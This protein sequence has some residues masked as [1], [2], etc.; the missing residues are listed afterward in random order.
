MRVTG[1]N[2]LSNIVKII[3]QIVLILGIIIIIFLPFLVNL[4]NKVFH[5]NLT[6]F[7]YYGYITLL[8]CASIPAIIL[9]YKF[10]K[11]FDTLKNN[12]PFIKEN[13]KNLNIAAICCGV[14]SFEFFVGMFILNSV[15]MIIVTGIFLVGAIGLYILAEL[16]KQA[17]AYKEENDLTI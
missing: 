1:K 5:I 13:A 9:V 8:Y 4:Y 6:G 7:E 16:F 17:V 3:L 11:M 15:F 12:N 2:S 10:I 14:I